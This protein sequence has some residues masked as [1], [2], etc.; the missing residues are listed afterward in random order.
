MRRDDSR[1]DDILVAN[2]LKIRLY[3]FVPGL[4]SD[5]GLIEEFQTVRGLWHDNY[6]IQTAQSLGN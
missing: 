3:G 4:I 2:T 1:G 5:K 6:L